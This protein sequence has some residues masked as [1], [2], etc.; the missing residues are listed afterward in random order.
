VVSHELSSI[1]TIADNS[2]FL[3]AD[4]RTI[5]ASGNPRELL[6]HSTDPAVQQFLTRGEASVPANLGKLNSQTL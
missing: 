3:D 2:I 6:Q 4:T 1:F 5:R